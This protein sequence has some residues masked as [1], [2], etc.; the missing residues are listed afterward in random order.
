MDFETYYKQIESLKH[1]IANDIH[2]RITPQIMQVM[3]AIHNSQKSHREEMEKMLL[4]NMW[5][6][7]HLYVLY[8]AV[9]LCLM[10]SIIR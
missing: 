9:A 6:K 7:H 2:T 5:S 10:I 1:D 4:R 3:D 8:A